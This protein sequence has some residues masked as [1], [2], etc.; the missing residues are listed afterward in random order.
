MS[1]KRKPP[2]TTDPDDPGVAIVQRAQQIV[3]EYIRRYSLPEDVDRLDCEEVVIE[4]LLLLPT[5]RARVTSGLQWQRGRDRIHNFL[6]AE[7]RATGR[8]WERP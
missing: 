2:I 8:A 6:D 5:E 3:T 1:A 7:A 4:A